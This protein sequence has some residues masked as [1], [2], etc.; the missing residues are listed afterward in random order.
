MKDTWGIPGPA[1]LAVY[2]VLLVLPLLVGLLW[3]IAVR[4]GRKAPRAAVSG[5]EPT[6][7]ELAFLAGGP[8]RVV[9]TAIAALVERGTLRVS[10]SKQLQLT[11]PMPADP[12][13][14]AV[15]K[16]A[17]PGYNATTRGMR[18][19]LRMSGPMQALAKDLE[20]RGLVVADRAPRVRQVVY[21]LYLAVLVL[22]VVRLIAGISSD[23]PVGFLVPLLIAA[24]FATLVARAVKN[25][26][27]GPR[28]TG[29]GDR[30]LH[31]AR[32]AH[33]RERKRAAPDGSAVGGAMLGGAV[34]GGA[35][36][37]VA[38]GGLSYYP[39][40]ELS[41]ALIPPPVPGGFG[42]GSSGGGGSS[43][44]SSSGGSSCSSGGSS[45]SSGGSS[46]GG[47][48]CGG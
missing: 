18:D 36:A 26:R 45:C 41:E 3:T 30:V 23:H 42:G 27:P 2:A 7:Y 16:G 13:E 31:R 25:K 4:V 47:G 14:K 5:P 37:A 9:D 12:I 6:V 8:D 38:F 35:A 28:P 46:C 34:L 39:D 20:A 15:A 24:G 44:G 32:S 22:G 21:F 33:G 29:E 1:F 43:C 11:G 19:R 40:E 48:G 10:S 17:K